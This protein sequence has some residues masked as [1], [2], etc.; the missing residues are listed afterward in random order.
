MRTL[1]DIL[2]IENIPEAPLSEEQKEKFE[3]FLQEIKEQGLEDRVLSVE[4]SQTWVV[5]DN[6]HQFSSSI[7]I[8]LSNDLDKIWL[9]LGR[10]PQYR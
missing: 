9:N 2:S 1:R 3:I 10:P 8:D 5:L 7:P 6:V 4:P